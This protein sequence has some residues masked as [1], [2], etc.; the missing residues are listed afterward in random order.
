ML[1]VFYARIEEQKGRE[2]GADDEEPEA[3][4]VGQGGRGGRQGTG[5]G[6]DRRCQVGN[7][8]YLKFF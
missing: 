1:Y 5:L 6:L 3:A 7:K 4:D 8:L 2:E